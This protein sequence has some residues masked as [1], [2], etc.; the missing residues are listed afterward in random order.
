ML[1]TFI[2]IYKGQNYDPTKLHNILIDIYTSLFDY[3][4]PILIY[5]TL[6]ESILEYSLVSYSDKSYKPVINE[7]KM[8]QILTYKKV[9]L[10]YHMLH[11]LLLLIETGFWR[12]PTT[13][14]TTTTNTTNNTS[15]IHTTYNIYLT[16]QHSTISFLTLI[17]YNEYYPNS[18]R[19]TCAYIISLILQHST[20]ADALLYMSTQYKLD[21]EYTTIMS[22]QEYTLINI[23]IK[24][25]RPIDYIVL[26]TSYLRKSDSFKC[27]HT[28][29]ICLKIVYT[30]LSYEYKQLCINNIYTTN[31]STTNNTHR[32]YKSLFDTI[33]SKNDDVTTSNSPDNPSP[34]SLTLEETWRWLLRLCYDRSNLV[35]YLSLECYRVLL[36]ILPDFT[37]K[38]PLSDTSTTNTTDRAHNNTIYNT[39]SGAGADT[40]NN[41]TT[42]P[43]ADPNTTTEA[44]TDNTTTATDTTDTTATLIDWSLYDHFQHIATDTS[45]SVLVREV[46][47]SILSTRYMHQLTHTPHT[48]HTPHTN[49]NYTNTNTTTNTSISI[50]NETIISILLSALA[51]A[52]D[53]TKPNPHP[54]TLQHTLYLTHIL[55]TLLQQQHSDTNIIIDRIKKLKIIPHLIQFLHFPTVKLHIENT[56]GYYLSY[57]IPTLQK[58]TLFTNDQK[59]SELWGLSGWNNNYNEHINNN[60]YILM[61]IQ[62]YIIDILYIIHIQQPILFNDILQHSSLYRYLFDMRSNI[63]VD[64]YHTNLHTKAPTTHINNTTVNDNNNNNNSSSS[65]SSSIHMNREEWCCRQTS[66]N[67]LFTVI[68]SLGRL[69][70]R[71]IDPITPPVHS[72]T[73]GTNNV[74]NTTY[75][76]LYT[77]IDNSTNSTSNIAILLL[78]K[79]IAQLESY[80]TYTT[81]NKGRGKD[82]YTSNTT[83]YTDMCI[84]A[85]TL[86]G[87]MV[88]YTPV[89]Q[90]LGWGSGK[91]AGGD[92]HSSI[93]IAF[94]LLCRIH[95]DMLSIPIQAYTLIYST[96]AQR[97]SY[98]ICRFINLS[99]T[100]YHILFLP[101]YNSTK[102]TRINN[103]SYGE[104]IIKQSIVNL[105]IFDEQY[106]IQKSATTTNATNISPIRTSNKPTPLRRDTPSRIHSSARGSVSRKE[107]DVSM[108]MSVSNSNNV[109]TI[110]RSVSPYIPRD[111]NTSTTAIGVSGGS[112]GGG[113]GQM[114]SLLKG[115]VKGGGNSIS[116]SPVSSRWYVYTYVHYNIPLYLKYLI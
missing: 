69:E 110:K 97:I 103:K 50:S 61:N 115:K 2:T 16:K 74:W 60:I 52:I 65:S 51:D 38:I 31:T 116:G 105:E 85:V 25:L 43:T 91:H 88:E 13:T 71:L 19:Y 99:H 22:R 86:L 76:S 27:S 17:I 29:C 63:L 45:E 89:R 48:P 1:Y 10:Q 24:R 114:L 20:P 66:I 7:A 18:I 112:G 70:T 113:R 42:N 98:L 84:S 67:T 96:I 83:V 94:D 62:K 82:I 6:N 46:C 47:L 9:L 26:Y 15:N 64:S 111:T 39:T 49:S 72:A 40:T 56:Y 8:N 14:P 30:C 109:T 75:K 55:Y 92:C 90:R 68:L 77:Y 23:H 4:Y 104:I 87:W 107:N 3:L 12:T 101:Q 73:Y 78:D 41:S 21:H 54:S 37:V 80:Y 59:G 79:V 57:H 44:T 28:L 32:V 58:S 95:N 102:G 106:T 34:S 53:L 33:A 11:M 108:N 35:K 81:T 100:C 5:C 36:L 93:S